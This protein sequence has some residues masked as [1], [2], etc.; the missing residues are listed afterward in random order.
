M[1]TSGA[2]RTESERG[3]AS[4]ELLGVLPAALLA[5]TAAWQLVLAGHTVW[6][7]GNAARVGARAAAVGN[8]PGK[9]AR[10]ALPDYL[11][12]RLQVRRRGDRVVVR[13]RLPSIVR[14]W[15]TPLS[16]RASAAL[17]NQR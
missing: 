15:D 10:S 16:L 4:V 14:A 13:V 8:D 2:H 6:L 7:A 9:A 11:E 1:W 5:V 3:Q 12:R 17:A